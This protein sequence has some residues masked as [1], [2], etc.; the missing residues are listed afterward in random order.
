MMCLSVDIFLFILTGIH[1]TSWSIYVCFIDYVKAFD[2]VNHNKLWKILQEM[3][4]PDTSHASW[5]ICM[6]VKKQQL[7]L[8]ME[9]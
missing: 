7:G 9:Q 4:I 3:G 5:E 6:Q 2:C 8:D 1:R